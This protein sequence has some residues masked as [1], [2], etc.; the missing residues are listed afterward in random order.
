[1]GWGLTILLLTPIEA[2]TSCNYQSAIEGATRE[3]KK[4]V[5][6]LSSSLMVKPICLGLMVRLRQGN[7]EL[8]DPGCAV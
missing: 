7:D 5:D 3:D 2:K 8:E 6:Q 1:M 4:K